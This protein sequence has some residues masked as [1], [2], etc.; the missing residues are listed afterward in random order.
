MG[1]GF[2]ADVINSI[3]QVDAHEPDARELKDMI[4]RWQSKAIAL[5]SKLHDMNCRA[6]D[7][8]TLLHGL[9]DAYDKGDMVA[10][11]NKLQ[12]L[13]DYRKAHKRPAAH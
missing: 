4:H 2:M 8:N 13:S 1:G 12:E 11:T 6:F 9:V 3:D 7:L 10:I 5:S